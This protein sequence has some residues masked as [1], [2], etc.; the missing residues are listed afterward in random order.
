VSQGAT[1]DALI[2]ADPGAALGEA[3][4]AEFGPQLPFL[5][6]VLAAGTPLS[7]QVHPTIAQAQAGFDAEDARGVPR[8]AAQRNYRDRNH[9]PELLCALTPFDALCG[10]RPV[11]DTL[12]LLAELDVPELATIAGLLAGADGLRAAFTTMLSLPDPAPLVDAVVAAARRIGPDSEWAGPASA[13]AHTVE[14]FPGDIGVVLSL[15]LNHVRLEPGEAIYLGAG[16]VH[17]YVRGMGVEIMANSDNVLR[18]GLTSKHVDVPELLRVTDFTPLVQPR[19]PDSGHGGFGVD[20]EVPVRDFHLYSA[21]LDAYRKPGREAGSCATGNAWQPYLVLC[22]S[23]WVEVDAEGT[24]VRLDPGQAAF[25]PAREAAFTL[26]GLGQ[27]FL[28]TVG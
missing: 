3:V 7:M 9:K 25:V 2:A 24:V 5:L 23:G 26:R 1:L 28:A 15:L 21:D 13:V 17:A 12:R 22:T 10:F 18:C 11:A 8:D 20:F 6:K 4:V 19:W 27:T 14:E 16:N